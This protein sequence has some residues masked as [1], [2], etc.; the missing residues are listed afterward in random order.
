M[1][2]AVH[3]AAIG[4]NVWTMFSPG[5]NAG[6]PSS[7]TPSRT[8]APTMTAI[9]S[10]GGALPE[11]VAVIEAPG[12]TI[13]WTQPSGPGHVA[14]GLDVVPVGADDEGGVVIG[15]VMRPQPWRA[16]VP[17]AGGAR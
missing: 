13:P 6:C 5:S 11:S 8:G 9:A 4:C 12:E 1:C 3:Q 10:K 16:I 7:S 14:H 17:G 2:S 15:V